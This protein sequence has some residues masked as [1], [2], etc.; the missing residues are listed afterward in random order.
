MKLQRFQN[1]NKVIGATLLCAA[2]A[3]GGTYAYASGGWGGYGYDGYDGYDRYGHGYGKFDDVRITDLD[4]VRKFGSVRLWLELKGHGRNSVEVRV[5]AHG[6]VERACYNPAGKLVGGRCDERWF[7]IK[8]RA[9]LG[10]VKGFEDI[11]FRLD[12]DHGFDRYFYGW[13]WGGWGCPGRHR[14]VRRVFIHDVNVRVT[15]TYTR[16]TLARAE[17]FFGKQFGYRWG[18]TGYDRDDWA[19][20]DIFNW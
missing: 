5:D 19:D 17:C 8:E 9:F 10:K 16:R 20:C 18:Y 15:D 6:L 14:S 1:I 12:I 4:L 7:N 2:T 3:L 13:D 11:F